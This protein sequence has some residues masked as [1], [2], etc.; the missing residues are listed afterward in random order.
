MRSLCLTLL[1]M[2]CGLVACGCQATDDTGSTQ[3]G[4]TTGGVSTGG[5]SGDYTAFYLPGENSMYRRILVRKVNVA[6]GL[7][8]TVILISP[9]I[10]NES[11]TITLPPMWG[12]EGAVVQQA[13]ADC[14]TVWQLPAEAGFAELGA[15]SAAWSQE[16]PCP[17]TLDIDVTLEFKQEQPWEPVKDALQASGIPVQG[18]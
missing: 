6:A 4:A 13:A 3:P 9:P 18:C 15:G 12:V 11:F 5:A 14:L 10:T 8:T 17:S 2:F 7:C 16:T 1:G